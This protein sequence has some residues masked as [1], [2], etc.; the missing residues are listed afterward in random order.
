M[1]TPKKH[2]IAVA[3]NGKRYVQ[4]RVSY[5]G[6]CEH[7][8]TGLTAPLGA[9]ADKKERFKQGSKVDGVSY[10][11][12][13]RKLNDYEAFVDGFVNDTLRRGDE[14]DLSR[15]KSEFNKLKGDRLKSEFYD[16]WDE[17]ISM[18]SRMRGWRPKTIEK[19]KRVRNLCYEFDAELSFQSLTTSK[20]NDLISFFAQTMRNNTIMS[21]FPAL[22]EY[23]T[24]ADKE[25]YPVNR[26]FRN[27][28][29][30]LKLGTR[31][32][33]Y[34]RQEEVERIY[35]LKLYDG[36]TL[37]IVRDMF[38]FQCEIAVRDSDLH[39]IK[40]SDIWQKEN[41]FY[42]RIHTRK[43]NDDI[44]L[45]LMTRARA[46][47]MKYRDLPNENDLLFPRLT[48]QSYNRNLKKIGKLADIKND[49]RNTKCVL[50]EQTPDP[51]HRS[52]I[53]SH[54]ARHTFIVLALS[55]G[56]PPAIVQKITGHS[57]YNA[58]KPYVNITDDAVVNAMKQIDNRLAGDG[59]ANK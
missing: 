6:K 31:E 56:I 43:D 22:K 11:I 38:V 3:K 53:E 19:H 45:P 27:F 58:M 14:I 28:N 18:R 12:L 1:R 44:E 39:E 57:S 46:I 59:V 33:R 40:K 21:R 20:L 23:V 35:N 15:L 16:V 47:Y 55:F 24:W 50:G 36:S 10:D 13:N 9:W 41:D 25:N 52:D 51:K 54:D 29:L 30:K 2:F 42:I 5:K 8:Y 4:L 48:N 49:Y 37:D 7:L 26:D 32:P 17:Y 34:L